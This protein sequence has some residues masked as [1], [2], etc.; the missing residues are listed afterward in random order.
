M[1]GRGRR[2]GAPPG[3][4]TGRI[5]AVISDV[6]TDCFT[7]PTT[8]STTIVTSGGS[9]TTSTVLLICLVDKNGFKYARGVMKVFL[10]QLGGYFAALQ[11]PQ[12]TAKSQCGLITCVRCVDRGQIVGGQVNRVQLIAGEQIGGRG[13][14][15]DGNDGATGRRW[16]PGPGP[17]AGGARGL[18]TFE[19]PAEL[20]V[21]EREFTFG[22][23]LRRRRRRL[24]QFQQLGLV[25]IVTVGGGIK[26]M[27]LEWLLLLQD[28][29]IF[30]AVGT[31]YNRQASLLCNLSI[32]GAAIPKGRPR[33]GAPRLMRMLLLVGC[34]GGGGVMVLM[35]MM[36]VGVVRMWVAIW[37]RRGGPRLLLLHQVVMFRRRLVVVLVVMVVGG[38]R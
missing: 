23:R 14:V 38:R 18:H 32:P 24:V 10:Q 37:T 5:A 3:F 17:G 6:V 1:G 21:D 34:C 29:R 28:V 33:R 30:S 9:T 26:W 7:T 31:S 22:Q 4:L 11:L 25:L 36:M 19:L 27:I 16:R 2:R 8:S 12:E 13:P 35:M 20:A 15:H